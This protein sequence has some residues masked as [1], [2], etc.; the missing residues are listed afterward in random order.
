MSLTLCGITVAHGKKN[1]KRKLNHLCVIYSPQISTFARFLH[2]MRVLG[3]AIKGIGVAD[4]EQ[5]GID[6]CALLDIL[7]GHGGLQALGICDGPAFK[8]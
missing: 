4:N 3:P 1:A 2:L 7:Q 8:G 6:P 5:G